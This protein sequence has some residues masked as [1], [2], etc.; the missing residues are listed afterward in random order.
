V[1]LRNARAAI[2][3]KAFPGRI[4]KLSLDGKA[5]GM[6]GKSGKQLGQ[7]GDFQRLKVEKAN[8]RCTGLR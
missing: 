8:I 6:F 3:N 4:Y 7:F 5:L 1:V 2:G